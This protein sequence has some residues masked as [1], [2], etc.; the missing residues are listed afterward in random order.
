MPCS[1]SNVQPN[2]ELRYAHTAGGSR[3]TA[4]FSSLQAS[5]SSVALNREI[6]HHSQPPRPPFPIRF[7]P[8][9]L[10]TLASI[11]C[12]SPIDTPGTAAML[13]AALFRS[14]GAAAARSSQPVL[15]HAS[16]AA[17]RI[18][19]LTSSS[20][21]APSLALRAVGFAP[22]RCYASGPTLNK[23]EVEGRIL[24]LLKGFDKVRFAGPF[25]ICGTKLH[26]RME[27]KRRYADT[28]ISQVNDPANVR[29]RTFS[30]AGSRGE[31]Y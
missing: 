21:V 23:P 31:R 28:S 2:R 27:M 6:Y 19:A 29:R 7:S 15:S 30:H 3:D 20:R 25:P 13:R 5:R 17:R 18:S 26:N 22:V 1:C 4:R 14:A 9:H 16:V 11:C 8:S 10:E 12:T 24:S